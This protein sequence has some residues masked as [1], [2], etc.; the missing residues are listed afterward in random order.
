L[1]LQRWRE[2]YDDRL[3]DQEVDAMVEAEM[4]G[5]AAA[6]D[7]TAPDTAADTMVEA[8]RRGAA[9]AADE[10]APDTAA[11]ETETLCRTVAM[12]EASREQQQQRTGA[13]ATEAATDDEVGTSAAA[14][15]QPP[16]PLQPRFLSH[17]EERTQLGRPLW[18]EIKDRVPRV[19]HNGTLEMPTRSASVEI[20]ALQ[21]EFPLLP[22]VEPAPAADAG[23]P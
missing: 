17:E 9:A 22:Y 2:L 4:R 6:V 11:P 1:H 8:E 15:A 3:L 21:R 23:V 5:A 14:Q 7:E 19:Q 20:K 16:P 10:T 18:T 13:T 12:T